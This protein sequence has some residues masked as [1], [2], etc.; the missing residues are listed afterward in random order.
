[1][2]DPVLLAIQGY[3][4]YPAPAKQSDYLALAERLEQQAA[5]A[6]GSMVL[7]AAQALREAHA[8]ITNLRNKLKASGRYK[9]REENERLRALLREAR[10]MCED[11]DGLIDSE[12]LAARIDAELKP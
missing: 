5:W 7:E 8:E 10:A 4:P 3:A 2:T 11:G 1:M 12:R 9:L 6:N